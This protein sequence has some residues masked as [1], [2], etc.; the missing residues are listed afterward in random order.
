MAC[1]WFARFVW[2]TQSVQ[3]KHVA[4]PVKQSIRDSSLSLNWLHPVKHAAI[5]H[6]RR[7]KNSSTC[8]SAALNG[9]RCG[10]IDIPVT[11]PT[12]LPVL[13]PVV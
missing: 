2:Y 11:R 10:V 13:V 6:V 1:V 4:L 3:H 8:V 5:L 7:A 9:S 12:V